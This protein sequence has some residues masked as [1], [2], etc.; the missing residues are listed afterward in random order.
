MFYKYDTILRKGRPALV[1][2]ASEYKANSE[3]MKDPN[4]VLDICTNVL[5]LH[6]KTEEFA[7][8][9]CLNT[10]LKLMGYFEVSR[11]TAE[12]SLVDPKII[13]QKALLIGASRIIFVHNH[14]SG[15]PH[16]SKE[17]VDITKKIVNGARILNLPLLDHMIIG[18]SESNYPEWYSIK[19]SMPELWKVTEK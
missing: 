15:D 18:G 8:T 6:K 11:G 12:A 1:K 10:R 17:D 7:Y 4:E 13:F 2:E 9:L 14:P 19:A 5:N 3:I 16:P